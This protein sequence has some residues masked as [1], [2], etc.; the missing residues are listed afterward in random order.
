M[1]P[2][3]AAQLALRELPA[4]TSGTAR[5]TTST[6]SPARRS[7]STTPTPPHSER[8]TRPTARDKSHVFI[9]GVVLP[10]ADAA[11]FELL[12]RSGFA[13]DRDHVYQRD[14]RSATTLPTSNCST[15]SSPKTVASSTGATDRCSPTTRA[16]RDRLHADHYLYTKDGSTVHV[17]GNP[18]PD[19]DPSTFQVL[20]GAYARDA[21]RVFYFDQPI[22]DADLS[23][24]RPLD[25]PYATD[26]AHVYWMGKTIDGA[27]RHLPCAEREL[28]M[29]G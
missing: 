14:R 26:S 23:S 12:D 28:R 19:A 20:Q 10:D 17:N 24:F 4:T 7:K 3:R 29:L 11:S 1:Q 25:G 18:I 2:K 22:A 15:A 13:K 16:L 21:R 5:C 6:P 27:T 9:N 8:S